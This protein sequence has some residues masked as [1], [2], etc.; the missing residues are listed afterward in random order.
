MILFIRKLLQL[1]CLVTRF[2]RED[3]LALRKPTKILPDMMQFADIVSIAPL[4]PVS[5]TTKDLDEVLLSLFC[6][7][8]LY[9]HD[10]NA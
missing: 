10:S 9:F 8:I 1:L 7:H 4:D 6:F 2:F 5:F 3:I